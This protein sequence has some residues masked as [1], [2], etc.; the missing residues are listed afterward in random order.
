LEGKSWHVNKNWNFS[1]SC[2]W[3]KLQSLKQIRAPMTSQKQVQTASQKKCAQSYVRW[4][5]LKVLEP[6]SWSRIPSRHERLRPSSQK[7]KKRLR[8]TKNSQERTSIKTINQWC[9]RQQYQQQSRRQRIKAPARA[10][11]HERESVRRERESTGMRS[12]LRRN[13]FKPNQG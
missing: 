2:E 9:N 1:C 6:A 8:E 13:C 5:R 10:S 7:E 11:A 4:P 12:G 3:M